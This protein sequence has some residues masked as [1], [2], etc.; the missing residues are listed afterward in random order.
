MWII[1]GCSSIGY[2]AAWVDYQNPLRIALPSGVPETILPN[3]AVTIT[4]QIDES[5]DAY[6]PGTGTLHYRYDGG[7]YQTSALVHLGGDLYEA[8]LPP[9]SCDDTPEYYFSAEGVN[10]GTVYN[11]KNAPAVTHSS[12]VGQLV[13]LFAD[14][15]ESDLGWT[16]ENDP[17][18]TDGAWNRGIPVGGGD[19]GDPPT[20]YDGSGKC[21][22]TDNADDN[23]DVDGGI[24][25]LISPTLD[26]SDGDD[27]RVYYALWYTNNFGNDPNNDLFKT[28][29]SNNNGSSWILAETIGPATTSGWKQHS[30]MIGDYVTPTSQVKVRFEASDLNDGSV[31]EAGIDD[32]K[33]QRLDCTET[34][35]ATDGWVAGDLKLH[36]NVPNPF[37]PNTVIRYELPRSAGVTLSIYDVSGR[38]LRVLVDS[39]RQGAGEHTVQW[40][41]RDDGDQLVA[42]GVYFYRLDVDGRAFT[43]K[44]VLTK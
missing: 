41:G 34:D 20:D 11:P 43:K 10:S 5:G 13:E 36:A 15:F 3:Q 32:F 21:Y 23:S 24:T 44:M 17:G 1:Y 39:E 2:A 42:S 14:S 22:L 27:I 4:V 19:R 37:N 18:L 28:Y 29:V 6:I 16:V 40:D 8:T 38:V 33:V 31:V 12:L 25:W 9:A 30:F 7:T 35:V 26:A